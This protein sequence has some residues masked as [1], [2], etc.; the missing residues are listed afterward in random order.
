MACRWLRLLG[1]GREQ[2]STL[3][4]RL[5]AALRSVFGENA[6]EFANVVDCPLECLHFGHAFVSVLDWDTSAQSIKRLVD[7]LHSASLA[8]ISLGHQMGRLLAVRNVLVAGLALAARP[9]PR[10][11]LGH[12]STC[13]TLFHHLATLRRLHFRPARRDN[14]ARRWVASLSRD[15]R[16]L[17]GRHLARRLSHNCLAATLEGQWLANLLH[18]LL[19]NHGELLLSRCSKLCF[20]SSSFRSFSRSSFASSSRANR[21]LF[22]SE[23]FPIFLLDD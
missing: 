7:C 10:L 19:A 6:L 8:R 16:L 21:S 3:H 9:Q 20:R 4:F 11:A 22:L 1:C 12:S 17:A 14:L 13:P 18:F 15:G 23:I 2:W 5:G